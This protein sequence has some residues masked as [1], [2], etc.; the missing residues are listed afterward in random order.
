MAAPATER[1]INRF[2][3]MGDGGIFVVFGAGRPGELMIDTAFTV[4][5]HQD[6]SHAFLAGAAVRGMYGV[7][8]VQSLRSVQD[9]ENS[10]AKK[11][12]GLCVLDYI[13]TSNHVHLLVKDTGENVIA[14][15]MQVIAGRTVQ[16]YQ[17]RRDIMARSLR[18]SSC[19]LVAKI[20]KR[21]SCW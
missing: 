15:S 10:E 4:D 19:F 16:E 8:N 7:Q 11:R 9:V 17:Q 20:T 3:G 5:A 2:E 18:V 6:I 14:E 1:I 12:F 21:C 13:V